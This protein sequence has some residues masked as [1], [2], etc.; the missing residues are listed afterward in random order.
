V[1]VFVSVFVF[2][3]VSANYNIMS[4]FAL[5]LIGWFINYTITSYGNICFMLYIFE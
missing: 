5:V 3:F 1:F 4:V 2:V